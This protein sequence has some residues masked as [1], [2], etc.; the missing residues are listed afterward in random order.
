MDCFGA[1]LADYNRYYVSQRQSIIVAYITLGDF[2][3]N[4]ILPP[5]GGSSSVTKLSKIG[6]NSLLTLI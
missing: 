4:R 3:R 1:N 5:L 6:C 2:S